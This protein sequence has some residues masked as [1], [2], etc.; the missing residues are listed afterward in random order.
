MVGINNA[1]PQ[2]ALDVLG[3]IHQNG[4]GVLGFVGILDADFD[5]VFTG[6]IYW[7]AA[8]SALDNAP[9]TNNGFL[10]VL[11]FGTNIVH[12]FVDV[13]TSGLMMRSYNATTEEWGLW[14]E[15]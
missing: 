15:K 9:S 2:S 1:H 13:A 10:L 4:E 6:G 12:I 3:D 5:T 14:D 8:S 7:Y 11:S